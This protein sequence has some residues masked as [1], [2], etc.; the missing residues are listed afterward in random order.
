MRGQIFYDLTEFVANPMRTGIQRVSY[1]ILKNWKF[2]PQLAPGFISPRGSRPMLLPDEFPGLMG[3]LF[4]GN[5][6]IWKT[7]AKRIAACAWR[8]RPISAQDLG[9]F[10]GFLNPELFHDAGRAEFY[11][12][13]SEK[14]GN[15]I[16]WIVYDALPWL[17]PDVFPAGSVKGTMHYLKAMRVIPNLHFISAACMSD[18]CERILRIQRPTYRVCPLGSDGLGRAAPEFDPSRRRF[19]CLG[20]IEPRKNH[21]VILQAFGE[22][23]QRGIDVELAFVGRMG[24][25]SREFSDHLIALSRR[26]RRFVWYED[27][28]DLQV[29]ETV[30]SSRATIYASER[31]GFGLPP[32]ESLALGVPVIVSQRLPSLSN[33]AELGQVRVAEISATAISAAVM[34]LL[35][36]TV[37]AEKYG[38]ILSLK[39]S[40]WC[41]MAEA[42]H[43]AIVSS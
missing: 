33:I 26:E 32:L 12:A 23:W 18:F 25:S 31:E 34:R 7:T 3:K 14:T 16:H 6:G 27:L 17:N 20:T 9:R 5:D 13:L 19:A 42:L 39:I 15:Q 38:E 11:R 28:N 41:E 43:Q 22:L 2:S 21:D 24:W 4:S 40:T 29:R 1:E 8:G 30:K 36:D 10:E 37:A 35:D